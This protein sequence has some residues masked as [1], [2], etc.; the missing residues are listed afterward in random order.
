[1]SQIDGVA[2]GT[3]VIIVQ[4]GTITPGSIAG[5]TSAEVSHTSQPVVAGDVGF[6]MFNGATALANSVRPST[7][8]CTTTGTLLASYI[9]PTAGALTPTAASATAPYTLY[10]VRNAG[11]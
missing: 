8:R 9:N 1:M 7:F 5:P 10:I 11:L 3:S 2:S 4:S 6:L